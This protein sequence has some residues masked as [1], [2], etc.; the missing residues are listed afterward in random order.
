VPFAPSTG[1]GA[2]P[3][4]ETMDEGLVVL[5]ELELELDE[6]AAGVA[7]ELDV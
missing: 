4:E 5:L 2:E 6:V 1:A 7:L 3:V